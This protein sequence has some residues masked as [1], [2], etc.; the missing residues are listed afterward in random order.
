MRVEVVNTGSELML[1]LVLNSHQ[2]WLCRQLSDLGFSVARQTCVSDSGPDIE[3]AVRESLS[4]A[5]VVITTGG[6][7]PTADDVTRE[8]AARLLGRGLRESAGILEAIRAY[9][10]V[11]DR[12]MP[13]RTAVQALIIEGAMVLENR[14]GTAPGM[15][16]E[17]APNPFR[18][19]AMGSWL[20]LLPGPGRELRPMFRGPVIQLLD[21]LM[22][23][24]PPFVCRVLRTIGV[25]ESIL[26]ER[27]EKAL[28]EPGAGGLDLGYCARPG[29]V[30]VRIAARGEGAADKVQR[31][32]Q[33]VRVE[34]G[35]D[36]FG[37]GEETLEEIVVGFWPGA[38][39]RWRWLNHAPA[40][41]LRIG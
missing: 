41:V 10:A 30:D 22:P 26:Q 13:E 24:R 16:I 38:G 17:L 34:L 11:R 7:G 35:D 14:E 9:F 31:A 5:D 20:I 19:D 25:G 23:V 21:R 40:D 8:V 36:I 2:Q 15:A 37:T 1:G 4:R 3:C 18:A 32:E 33:R 28:G 29:Q 6:L 12:P 27:I 39:R